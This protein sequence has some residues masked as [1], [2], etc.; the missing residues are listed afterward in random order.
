MQALL[1]HAEQTYIRIPT[2]G[3]L[4]LLLWYQPRWH[5]LDCTLLPLLPLLHLLPACAAGGE[6]EGNG[7]GMGNT[8]GCAGAVAVYG[9]HVHGL[10]CCSIL[11]TLVCMNNDLRCRVKHQHASM[12][13][14]LV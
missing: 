12:L 1:C 6:L 10:G 2:G 11:S 4:S 13:C 8:P 9:L 3:Y 5:L 14:F 7:K